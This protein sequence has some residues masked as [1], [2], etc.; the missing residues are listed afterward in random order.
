MLMQMIDMESQLTNIRVA[1]GFLNCRRYVCR[2]KQQNAL[3]FQQM[4][5]YERSVFLESKFV[6]SRFTC[7]KHKQKQ[8]FYYSIRLEYSYYK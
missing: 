7:L 3:K 1:K 6:V 8:N 4:I 5:S 2:E